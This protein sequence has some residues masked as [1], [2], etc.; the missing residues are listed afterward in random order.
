MFSVWKW[1]FGTGVS[2]LET[3]VSEIETRVSEME[4][5]DKLNEALFTEDSDVGRNSC[6]YV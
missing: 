6:F 4:I 2:V 3:R 5:A 1:L